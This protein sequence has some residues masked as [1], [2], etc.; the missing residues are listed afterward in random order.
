[1]QLVHP[2]VLLPIVVDLQ[3]VLHFHRV[4]VHVAKETLLVITGL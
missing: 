2:H 1:M 3:L 4:Y